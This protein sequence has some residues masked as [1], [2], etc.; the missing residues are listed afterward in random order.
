MWFWA[1]CAAVPGTLLMVGAIVRGG[2]SSAE[3]VDGG[4]GHQQ[5]NSQGSHAQCH[6]PRPVLDSAGLGRLGA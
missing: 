3:Q 2:T 6:W 5:H 1:A 4:T